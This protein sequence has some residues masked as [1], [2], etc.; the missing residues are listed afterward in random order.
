TIHANT[1]RDALTRLENMISLAGLAL[2]PKNLRQQISSAISVVVQVAR[3]TDG[4]RKVVSIQE[5]TGMEGEMV[6][7][8]EIFTFRR[9]GVD[10]TGAVRGH[11]C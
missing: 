6:N 9:T 1:P 8:Q 5:L 4:R 2:P 10:Q 11:F 3:L 7:M